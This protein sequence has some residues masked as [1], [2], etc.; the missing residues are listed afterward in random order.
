MTKA[1]HVLVT[2]H[3]QNVGYR[4]GC[5]QTARS[6]GLVG[7]VRNLADG[8]VELFA[9]GSDEGV[10]RLLD[11]IWAGPV[12]ARVSGVETDVVAPDV[13]LT[14]FFIQANPKRG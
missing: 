4:Q 8:R 7:W 9:Q 10:D 1:V 5:R 2:G 12:A 3:V 6:L 13:T 11:W 14:D